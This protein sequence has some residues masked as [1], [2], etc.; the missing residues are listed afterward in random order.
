MNNLFKILSILII[1]FCFNNKL[2]ACELFNVAPGSEFSD[3]ENIIGE[4]G[5]DLDDYHKSDVL[6]LTVNNDIHCPNSNLKNTLSYIFISNKIFTGIEI[7]SYIENE[8]EPSEKDNQV[9]TFVNNNLGGIDSEVTERGWEGIKEIKTPHN[10]VLYSK[11]KK[12]KYT[13]EKVLITNE[14]NYELTYD[15]ELTE[16]N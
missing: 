12:N 3:V 8:T 1:S 11:S 13:V 16:I 14:A 6:R 4:I 7:T 15:E 10:I 5:T 9:Y 2:I